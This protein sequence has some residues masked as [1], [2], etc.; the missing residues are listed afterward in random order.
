MAHAG[1]FL[2]LVNLFPTG[3]AAAHTCASRPP[4]R[5]DTVR[6]DG[7][8]RVTTLRVRATRPCRVMRTRLRQPERLVLDFSPARWRGHRLLRQ[9]GGPVRTVRIAQHHGHRVRLVVDTGRRATR[10]SGRF[11]GAEWIARGRVQALL[12]PNQGSAKR[13]EG[14]QA[15]ASLHALRRLVIG[16]DAGH[17]G[18]DPGAIARSGLEEK[19]VTLG[20][21][22]QLR[23]LLKRLCIRTVMTRTDDRRLPKEARIAF[24][25]DGRA[26]LIVSIHCDALE[27]APHC[28]G[29]TTY[30]HGGNRRSQE[31]AEAVQEKLTTATRLPDR[32]ARPD[33]TR[34]DTGFYVLRNATCP[35]VLVETGYISSAPT[36]ARLREP[37][38]RLQ[39]ARGIM[40]GLQRYV[41]TAPVRTARR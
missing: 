30:F 2:G 3:S 9:A 5:I 24:V 34:Y 6:V 12:A 28:T 41:Q 1:I 20:I 33:T 29:I 22:R 7:H 25:S 39:V 19:K 23:R 35:A 27:G 17:G 32:G 21:A 4:A 18:D 36:A 40:E 16:I 31:L 14:A 15:R 38:F 11:H 8:D 26:N 13:E 37:G 10:W